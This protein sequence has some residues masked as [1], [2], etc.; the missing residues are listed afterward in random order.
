[1]ERREFAVGFYLSLQTRQL[2]EW[3]GKAWR[4]LNDDDHAKLVAGG[5]FRPPKVGQEFATPMRTFGYTTVQKYVAECDHSGGTFALSEQGRHPKIEWLLDDGD[6]RAR[7]IQYCDD[8]GDAKG[9]KNLR[10]PELTRWVNE[11]LF[12]VGTPAALIDKAVEE[13]TVSRWLHRC[14]FRLVEHQKGA[15]KD[16]AMD[17]AVLDHMFGEFLPKLQDYI[18]KGTLLPSDFDGVDDIDENGW[19]WRAYNKAKARAERAR[20][21]GAKPYVFFSH[22]EA[23]CCSADDERLAYM[24]RGRSRIKSKGNSNTTIMAA[25]A[26][27]VLGNRALDM[28]DDS[29]SK[30]RPRATT[31]RS[32]PWS[33]SRS[34]APR[35]T[36]PARPRTSRAC[37]SRRTKTSST[38]TVYSRRSCSR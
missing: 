14:R 11:T 2:A 21:E 12:K 33:S 8:H 5:L 28:T 13:R 9:E 23:C 15:Y 32:R 27:S 24:R 17:D 36:F 29:S 7:F 1:M 4:E 37:R 35:R 19:S 30:R 10:V 3:D 38:S 20:G 31:G 22:D 34:S 25:Y 16:G 6:L 18:D 26:V